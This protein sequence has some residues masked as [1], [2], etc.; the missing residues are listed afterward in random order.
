MPWGWWGL[1]S[2]SESVAEEEMVATLTIHSAVGVIKPSSQVVLDEEF[3]VTMINRSFVSSIATVAYFFITPITGYWCDTN[4]G[5][6]DET[7]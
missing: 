7:S 4:Y 3:G 2:E 1:G 6:D 5:I